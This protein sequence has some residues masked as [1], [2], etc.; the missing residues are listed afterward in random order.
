MKTEEMLAGLL[1]M[2]RTVTIKTDGYNATVIVENSKTKLTGHG[3]AKTTD[4]DIFLAITGH[5]Q[6]MISEDV[7]RAAI[8]DVWEQADAL[9]RLSLGL[10]KSE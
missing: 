6:E 8:Y 4:E 9:A 2:G 7:I 5:R 3:Y 10:S 1:L